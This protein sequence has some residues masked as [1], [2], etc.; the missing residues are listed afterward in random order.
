MEKHALG[1]VAV[2]L[3]LAGCG[4][5]REEHAPAPGRS[6]FDA[7]ANRICTEARTRADRLARLRALR[8]PI[9]SEDPYL[10]WLR[11]E[12]GALAAAKA[13]ADP[14]KKPDADPSVALAVAEGTIMG[15]ARRLGAEACARR[16][17]GT[18]PP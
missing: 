12:E 9:G 3:A 5:G 14:S 16:R 11:A 1:A 7:R 8:P 2:C 10:H 4:S 13:L 6:A 18:M 17:A 15:Y